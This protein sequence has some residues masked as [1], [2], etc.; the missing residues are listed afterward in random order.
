MKK[1]KDYDFDNRRLFIHIVIIKYLI[2][3]Q[4]NWNDFFINL[5]QLINEYQNYIDL[6]LI[7]FP[8]NWVEILSKA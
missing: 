4:K 1:H 6:K 3:D 7:G 5:Q 2:V 8:D